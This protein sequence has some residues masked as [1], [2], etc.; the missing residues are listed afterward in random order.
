V[1][2]GSSIDHLDVALLERDRAERL[3]QELSNRLWWHQQQ[4]Q[5]AEQNQDWF[6]AVFH[7]GQLLKDIPPISMGPT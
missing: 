2:H 1:D 5:Q 6:A 7:L 4:A 3:A